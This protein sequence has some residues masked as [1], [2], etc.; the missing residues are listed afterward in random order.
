MD[1]YSNWL[2][3]QT[4][5]VYAEFLLCL[6]PQQQYFALS[7]L[8]ASVRYFGTKTSRSYEYGH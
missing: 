7:G 1:F 3:I 8:H 4:L 2:S 6:S 5:L